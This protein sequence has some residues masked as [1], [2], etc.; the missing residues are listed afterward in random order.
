M[1]GTFSYTLP[2]PAITSIVPST[3]STAGGTP[4][5]INGTNFVAGLAATIGGAPAIITTVNSSAI[6]ATTPMGPFDIV[7]SAPRD[8]VVT[9]PDG[10]S[11]TRSGGFTY[12]LPAPS[13]A[14][15][16]PTAGSP[17]GG[18]QVTITGAGF[19]T[20]LPVSVTFG[21]VAGTNV[22]VTSPVTLN[23][24]APAQAVGTVDVVVKVGSAQA[25][26]AGGFSYQNP[27]KKRR[28]V[29]LQ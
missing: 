13:I 27:A 19:T 5:T 20:A 23:V 11:V 22:Q 21:G 8:V 10:R 14:S 9:N 2:G 12:T 25:T 1:F 6:F 4:I 24:T 7:S 15:I 28:A 26:S 29:K 17:N 3:G 18:T 16:N